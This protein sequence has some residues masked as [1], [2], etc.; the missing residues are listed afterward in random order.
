VERSA[1]SGVGD[2]VEVAVVL[3]IEGVEL[4]EGGHTV[5]RRSLGRRYVPEEAVAVVLEYVEC[6]GEVRHA[7]AEIQITVS[8]NVQ[9]LDSVD[10]RETQRMWRALGGLGAERP[11][12]GVHQEPSGAGARVV[13]GVIQVEVA[14]AIQVPETG[15]H[16]VRP[17]WPRPQ[18][19]GKN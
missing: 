6:V 5:D 10:V 2:Q 7:D 19:I 14:V 9:H 18:S 16:S 17:E 3:D 8:V 1:A 4:A 12:S 15:V 11:V 13:D